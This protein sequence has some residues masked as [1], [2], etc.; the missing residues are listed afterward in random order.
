MAAAIERWKP[1][2]IVNASGYVRIDDAESDRERCLRENALGPAVLADACAGAG[3]RLVTF[4]SD[5]VFD[6]RGDRPWLESDL[7]APLNVYGAS[8]AD[9]EREALARCPAAMV[10]RTSA[11]FGPWDRHNFVFHAARAR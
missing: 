8:K 11:F 4:S 3:I 5:Q 10:V 2:A 9:G 6:G 1:W 7:P